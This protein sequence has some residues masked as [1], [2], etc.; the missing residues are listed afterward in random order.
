MNANHSN[1]SPLSAS[2]LFV[3]FLFSKFLTPDCWSAAQPGCNCLDHS[4]N[5]KRQQQPMC[6][7]I[8]SKQ[9][10]RHLAFLSIIGWCCRSLFSLLLI[11]CRSCIHCL[12]SSFHASPSFR[13]LFYCQSHRSAPI[14][15]C[16]CCCSVHNS[17]LD[18]SLFTIIIIII[19]NHT[20]VCSF[21]IIHKIGH[22]L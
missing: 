16:C 7:I 18:P 20:F 14:A 5:Q 3:G 15:S 1:R 21:R 4:V 11:N 17:D 22:L 8:N 19:I 12:L 6:G 9:S 13:H 10:I 2:P